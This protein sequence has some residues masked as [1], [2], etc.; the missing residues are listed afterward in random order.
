[1]MSNNH[2]WLFVKKLH[3]YNEQNFSFVLGEESEEEEEVQSGL[4]PVSH[5]Q[6]PSLAWDEGDEADE[7]G[8]YFY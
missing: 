7:E 6:E 3:N 2:R 1:M 4:S 8:C 5:S